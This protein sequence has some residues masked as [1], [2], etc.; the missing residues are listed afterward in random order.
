MQRMGLDLSS[1][2]L[3]LDAGLIS[4]EFSSPVVDRW[5]SEQL[6]VPRRATMKWLNASQWNGFCGH[7]PGPQ[8]KG[9]LASQKEE[10]CR[11]LVSL[12]TIQNLCGDIEKRDVEGLSKRP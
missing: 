9:E 1:E 5:C 4:W 2:F 7:L 11:S 6:Q 8:C 10:E 3:F 12:W